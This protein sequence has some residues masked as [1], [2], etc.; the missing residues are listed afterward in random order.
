MD[1]TAV[2][3][4]INPVA[5][6]ITKA[7]TNAPAL[8]QLRRRLRML[9]DEY[10]SNEWEGERRR[11]PPFFRVAYSAGT[12]RQILYLRERLRWRSSR[13]DCMV[14]ALTLGALHGEV[15]SGEAY[16][17]NQMPRTISTK[18]AYSMRFWRERGLRAPRRDVFDVLG[19]AATYR[20]ETGVPLE[21]ATVTNTDIREMP[22]H[23]NE[24]PKPLRCVITSP[25]YLDMTSFEEDQWLR[26]WFLGSE[27]FPT[28]GIISSDDRHE[29]RDSYWRLIGDMWRSLAQ[30]LDDR[31][32]IVI[33][34]GMRDVPPSQI[35]ESLEG[36]A[37]IGG[38]RVRLI[39]YESG[40]IQRR[41]TTAFRPGST[42]VQVEVD[43]H[44]KMT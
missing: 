17:S 37:V 28:R 29:N 3:N 32:N 38:R 6:C 23:M 12:L 4:D 34:I 40:E 18:P 22:R 42:G 39:S 31:A 13:V 5:Y 26:L 8:S 24:F 19:R 15:N 7:K 11:L 21:S 1:R 20:Y 14:A 35:A 9:H 25:P 43:C 10:D 44:F 2:G 33:R 27:P 41:Q 30:L 36:S 16:L